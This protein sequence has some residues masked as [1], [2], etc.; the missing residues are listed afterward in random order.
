MAKS[1]EP[2]IS[3]SPISPDGAGSHSQRRDRLRQLVLEMAPVALVAASLT[4]AACPQEQSYPPG[5]TSLS[6]TACDRCAQGP[7]PAAPWAEGKAAWDTYGGE[8]IVRLQIIPAVEVR[9]PDAYTVVGGMLLPATTGSGE[10]LIKPDAGAT[11][12]RLAGALT[13]ENQTA[14]FTVTVYLVAPDYDPNARIPDVD[15]YPL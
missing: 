14:P 8:T 4:N 10:M 1:D 2:D 11:R 9:L 5:C 15:V 7:G 13:C 12:I 3:P 6:D